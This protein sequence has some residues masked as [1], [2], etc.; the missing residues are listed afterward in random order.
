MN[1]RHTKGFTLVE[2]LIV[3]AIIAILVALLLPAVKT[4]RKAAQNVQC[5]N[6]LRQIGIGFNMYA[7]QFDGIIIPY[8][9]AA[10][11]QWNG[12]PAFRKNMGQSPKASDQWPVGLLCPAANKLPLSSAT[13]ADITLTYGMNH[14]Q[15][16]RTDG[17]YDPWRFIKYIKV[18]QVPRRDKK[19]M[20]ADAMSWELTMNDSDVYVNDNATVSGTN[21]FG[22]MA[23]RHGDQPNR[24]DNSSKLQTAN[25]LFYDFHVETRSRVQ[26][27]NQQGVWLWWK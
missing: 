19:L 10:A 2:L 21:M 20:V 13:R 11:G 3:V 6:N 26:I 4:V 8:N 22:A 9:D 5:I 25:V 24:A 27:V 16:R 23:Y 15:S 12:N 17:T 18:M 14:E 7:M 1:K